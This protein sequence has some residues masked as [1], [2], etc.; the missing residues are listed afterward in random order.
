MVQPRVRAGLSGFSGGISRFFA[1]S[2]RS[3]LTG[4]SGA[5][6]LFALLWVIPFSHGAD[7]TDG[8]TVSAAEFKGEGLCRFSLHE[9]QL[10]ARNEAAINRVVSEALKKHEKLFAF[11]AAADFHVRVRIFGR[12]ADFDQYTRTNR[13]AQKFVQAR[14]SLTNLGGYYSQRENQVVTWR[15]RHPT[16][17]ANTLLHEASH[18]ILHTAFRRVPIWLS[19]GSATYFAYPR[20]IQDEKDVGNLQYRWAKL[21]VLLRAKQLPP[22]RT[23]LNWKEDEWLGID[24]GLT[25]TVAWSMFQLLMS[26]PQKQE[27]LQKYLREL[28]RLPRRQAGQTDLAEVFA[29]TYPG[30]IE[31]LEKDWHAWIAKGGARVLGPEMDELLK[32]VK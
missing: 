1:G 8:E 23:V 25:Y 26:T 5:L 6:F 16:H 19:E 31:Q 32:Q 3:G 17:L 15:Q 7:D 30:G 28:Q 2:L 29:S 18:A 11:K 12:F 10:P 9:Y 14:Q 24:P 21:N 13:N 20:G 22:S 27:G 4:R